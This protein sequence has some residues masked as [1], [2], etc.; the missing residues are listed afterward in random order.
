MFAQMFDEFSITVGLYLWWSWACLFIVV[1]DGLTRKIQDGVSWC[2][3]F[4]DDNLIVNENKECLSRKLN[5]HGDALE[6]KSSNIN[7]VKKEYLICNFGLE[8]WGYLVSSI[9]PSRIYNI[10][11]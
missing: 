3:L 8:T 11:E 7:H 4:A 9:L 10:N 6:N 2:I 1:I 5:S